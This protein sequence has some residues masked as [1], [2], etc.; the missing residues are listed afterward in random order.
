MIPSIVTAEVAREH[1]A[2][3]RRQA[4]TFAA[5]DRTRTA[6]PVLRRRRPALRPRLA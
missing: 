4:R 5:G 6:G 3:L 1:Q 2:D